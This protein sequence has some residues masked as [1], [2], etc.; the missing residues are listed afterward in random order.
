MNM[1]RIDAY[2]IAYSFLRTV[3]PE[4]GRGAQWA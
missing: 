4:P 2:P 3:A 1:K